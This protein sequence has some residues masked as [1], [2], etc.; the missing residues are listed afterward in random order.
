MTV[1]PSASVSRVTWWLGGA[2]VDPRK[3]GDEPFVRFAALVHESVVAVFGIPLG[4]AGGGAVAPHEPVAA[5]DVRVVAHRAQEERGRRRAILLRWH[6]LAGADEALAPGVERR[7][8]P[9]ADEE[10]L[11]RVAAVFAEAP[12]VTEAPAETEEEA[13]LG[14]M[15]FSP[16]GIGKPVRIQ[17]AFVS[18]EEREEVIQFIKESTGE[19]ETNSELEAA[20]NKAA[21]M[22]KA[23]KKQEEE[24]AAAEEPAKPTTEELLTAILEEMKTQK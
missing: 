21:E 7:E 23:M 1:R 16:V 2:A 17:G 6:A 20:M 8:A 14:D 4:G 12:A 18:D 5:D 9:F 19:V 15:L 3:H 10:R 22:A 11:F 13:S 24:E